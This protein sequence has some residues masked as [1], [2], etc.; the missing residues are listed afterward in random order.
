MGI[1]VPETRYAKSGDVSMAYKV[2]GDGPFDL[3][4]TPGAISNVELV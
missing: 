1:A 4:W 3:I 2:L